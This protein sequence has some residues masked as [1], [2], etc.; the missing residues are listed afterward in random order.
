M[1]QLLN[2][3][4]E[5]NSRLSKLQDADG[6]EQLYIDLIGLINRIAEHVIPKD[7]PSRERIG[8]MMGG[9][10]LKLRSEELREEGREQS[11][12]EGRDE[13]RKEGRTLEIYSMVQDGDTSS[14]QAAKRLGI[15]VPVLRDKMAVAGYRYPEE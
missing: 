3:Y 5:I 14:E 8:E 4:Q 12:N 13:G 15:T 6:K 1:E 11:L 9:Q 2:D 10:I 7:N